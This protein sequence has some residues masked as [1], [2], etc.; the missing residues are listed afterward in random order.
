[1][2]CH[3][4]QKSVTIISKFDSLSLFRVLTNLYEAT[5]LTIG[6]AQ[7]NALVFLSKYI[8]INI[9]HTQSLQSDGP[10]L[11]I[12][13]DYLSEAGMVGDISFIKGC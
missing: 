4:Q 10:C 1:M 9:T 5:L 2:F 7:K 3:C 13:I 11:L 6:E 12:Y 8:A